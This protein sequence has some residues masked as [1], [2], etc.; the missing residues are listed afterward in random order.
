MFSTA[1]LRSSILGR[2]IPRSFRWFDYRRNSGMA[3]MRR[4][5]AVAKLQALGAGAALAGERFG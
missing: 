2:M 1:A 4:D 3:P 5:I